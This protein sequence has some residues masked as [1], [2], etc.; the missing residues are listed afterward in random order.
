MSKIKTK[1]HSTK[2][3]KPDVVLVTLESIRS[4]EFNQLC[5]ILE[6]SWNSRKIPGVFH[7]DCIIVDECQKLKGGQDSVLL[8]HLSGIRKRLAI[9]LTGT[10]IQNSTKEL[11]PLLVFL[12]PQMFYYPNIK[13]KVTPLKD[14]WSVGKFNERFSNIQ[15]RLVLKILTSFVMLLMIFFSEDCMQ[16][17]EEL[18]KLLAPFV[19][20]REKIN[21]LK[22][23]SP[24]NVSL[25]KIPLTLIQKRVY[26]AIYHR[27]FQL[28]NVL[29]V[30]LFAF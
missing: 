26:S 3:M 17:T 30:I 7:W 29:S 8:Q 23:L 6:S 1:G 18:H 16:R 20:R 21:V 4:C 25:I 9:L 10:P 12:N 2:L 27:Y 13:N 22:T 28:R 24:K 14:S 15:D 19:L 5:K 11:F